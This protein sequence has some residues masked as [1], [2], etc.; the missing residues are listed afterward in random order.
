MKSKDMVIDFSSRSSQ[1][2]NKEVVLNLY[3]LRKF[4]DF[5]V[6]LFS[7]TTPEPYCEGGW[8]GDRCPTEPLMIVFDQQVLQDR[9]RSTL[10]L[11]F[12]SDSSRRS[13]M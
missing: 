5:K 11:Y 3:I 9:S 13:E 10:L 8:W 4:S 12:E 1:T 2:F 6:D 7:E